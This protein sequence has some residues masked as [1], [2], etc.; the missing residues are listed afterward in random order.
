[1]ASPDSSC[2]LPIPIP[3]VFCMPNSS[4]M[5]PLPVPLQAAER[6]LRRFHLVRGGHPPLHRVLSGRGASRV[7]PCIYAPCVHGKSR[8]DEHAV[9]LRLAGARA[10]VGAG[11]GTGGRGYGCSQ[12]RW[13][14]EC[15]AHGDARRAGAAAEEYCICRIFH[16]PS[17]IV[18]EPVGG[19]SFTVG[20]A[21][22]IYH[23]TAA[24]GHA[25]YEQGYTSADMDIVAK[26]MKKYCVHICKDA[27]FLRKYA[28]NIL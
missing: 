16:V 4:S 2:T 13:C 27:D 7:L 5:P 19:D 15:T 21:A 18:Y 8:M 10:E 25:I 26:A 9:L 28:N 20:P 1:M 22:A 17:H 11:R 23:R 6:L 12:A 14:P 3:Q 24:S